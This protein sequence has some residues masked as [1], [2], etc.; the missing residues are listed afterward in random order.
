MQVTN[1]SNNNRQKEFSGIYRC[2]YGYEFDETT[3]SGEGLIKS[4]D[5]ESID[6][7]VL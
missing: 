3:L 7:Q 5:G 4:K 1:G 2:K 6:D